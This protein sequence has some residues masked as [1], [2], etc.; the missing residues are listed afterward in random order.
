MGRDPPPWTGRMA[1]PRGPDSPLARRI[2][3]SAPSRLRPRRSGHR[4]H[5]NRPV[6]RRL[7][8]GRGAPLG[9]PNGPSVSPLLALRQA[10]SRPL[11]GRRLVRRLDRQVF[12]MR[13]DR[14]RQ[15]RDPRRMRG[16]TNVLSAD[17]E[18][19]PFQPSSAT[20]RADHRSGLSSWPASRPPAGAPLGPP[21]VPDAGRPCSAAPRSTPYG[22]RDQ[23]AHCE[24]GTAPFQ[25][26]PAE[27]GGHRILALASPGSPADA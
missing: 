10:S 23:R 13:A 5:P 2:A 26:S 7:R 12:Q 16:V 3:P 1:L 6:P 18:Q 21:G 4:L 24:S 20:I 11:A 14:A 19:Q 8:V 17:L 15:G 25:P 27:P 22:R 9:P